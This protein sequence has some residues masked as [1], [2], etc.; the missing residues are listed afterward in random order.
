NTRLEVGWTILPALIL[1][2]VAVPTIKTIF[3]LS[4]KPTNNPLHVTVIG[5]Q[6][7]WEYQYTDPGDRVVTANE[8]HIPVGRPVEITLEPSEPGLGRDGVIHSFWVPKLGGKTDVV[9]G[10]RNTMHF[11]ADKVGTYLGQCVEFC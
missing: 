1:F 7:W 2:A 5:H 3:D 10:R 8:L 9:P 6:W 11:Q 4:R